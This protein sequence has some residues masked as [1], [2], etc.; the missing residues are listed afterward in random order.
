MKIVSIVP[1]IYNN[2]DRKIIYKWFLIG[3]FIRFLIMPFCFHEH[4]SNIYYRSNFLLQGNWT[5]FFGNFKILLHYIHALFL[6]IFKQFI[7]NLSNFWDYSVRDY[8][9]SWAVEVN[10][11]YI[12][13]I[14]FLFKIPYLFFDMFCAFLLLRFWDKKENGIFCFKFWMI[15]PI[16]IY[17]IYMICRYECISIFFVLLSLYYLKSSK[18][19][20]AS[21]WLMMSVLTRIYTLIFLPF[22]LVFAKSLKQRIKICLVFIISF[23]LLEGIKNLFLQ[24]GLGINDFNIAK[25]SDYKYMINPTI[26]G[27]SSNF[28]D[29]I[30][31]CNFF[32]YTYDRIFIFIVVYAL[33]LLHFINST[34]KTFEKLFKYLFSIILLLF[35]ICFFHPQYFMWAIPFIS[36]FITE[37]KKLISCYVI[38]TICF[39]VYVLQWDNFL[40]FGLFSPLSSFFLYSVK[41]PLKIISSYM[42]VKS[43][44]GIFRS[45]LS[46]TL[47]WMIYLIWKNNN[48][49][50][51][52]TK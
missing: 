1:K 26:E 3:L 37:N 50:K 49:K 31:S 51:F 32:L 30:L 52:E 28:L 17:V 40:T 2:I 35:A 19:L 44:I 23:F 20:K 12:F 7:P 6:L 4:I 13:R 15:N 22:Y 21:F 18:I 24:K 39:F 16:S 10:H 36:I 33:F 11:P 46:A 43:F 34:Q 8:P 14:L 41:S 48:E 38:M 5:D 29:Y 9:Y 42:P 25:L 27:G 45:I 47:L